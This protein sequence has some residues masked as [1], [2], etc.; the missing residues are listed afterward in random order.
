MVSKSLR[1]EK[2]LLGSLF[3][4]AI[5][6]RSWGGYPLSHRL[7]GDFDS[8]TIMGLVLLGS[9][10]RAKAQA[11]PP[12]GNPPASPGSR[13]SAS[14]GRWATAPPHH[15]PAASRPARP[16]G[17]RAF[18]SSATVVRNGLWSKGGQEWKE[19]PVQAKRC[20][21]L[22]SLRKPAS[23]SSLEHIEGL[24]SCWMSKN[25]PKLAIICAVDVRAW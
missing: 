6:V 11:H 1:S 4:L 22:I 16:K 3:L 17:A 9:G 21:G 10:T 15:P 7:G 18:P 8:G 24:G 5:K 23:N 12:R 25:S 19:E 13:P 2:V 20:L 14:R